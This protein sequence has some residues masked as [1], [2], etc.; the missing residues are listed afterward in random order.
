MLRCRC[1][2]LRKSPI[3]VSDGVVDLSRDAAARFVALR[4]GSVVRGIAYLLLVG[5]VLFGASTPVAVVVLTGLIWIHS[6]WLA[7]ADATYNA[8]TGE[9]S[10][11]F[12]RAPGQYMF[13]GRPWRMFRTRRGLRVAESMSVVGLALVLSAGLPLAYHSDTLV[14]PVPGVSIHN[15]E[16]PW[17]VL[18][19]IVFV[20]GSVFIWGGNHIERKTRRA[21]MQRG[22][23]LAPKRKV[24]RPQVVFLR[25][26]G[27]ESLML[28]AHPGG[29]RG[30]LTMLIPKRAEFL[31]DVSTWLFWTRGD[32][33]AV[34]DPAGQSPRT[35]GAAH[36]LVPAHEQWKQQVS[37]LMQRAVAIVVVP[38]AGGGISWEADQVLRN[39][40][41]ARKTLFVNP[42]PRAPGDFLRTI[43]ASQTQL[44]AL[45]RQPLLPLAAVM[46]P[47]GPRLLAGSLAE[48]IDMDAAVEWFLRHQPRRSTGSTLLTGLI[49]RL[50]RRGASA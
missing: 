48:D 11:A 1:R 24:A 29:R 39:R 8:L 46:T 34:A 35:L 31:E 23:T 26:F 21:A 47:N 43:E 22:T 19:V 27:A 17:W 28:P 12:D 30:G 33:I 13:P 5:A 18:G 4:V 16:L 6:R 38:G 10:A 20:I 45:Y 14:T 2:D 40:D 32:V 44:E 7:A 37:M 49:N 50:T 3:A 9:R 15:T 25:P 41:H 36:H 42:A